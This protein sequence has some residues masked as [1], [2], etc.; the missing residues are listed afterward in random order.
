MLKLQAPII[1]TFIQP[2]NKDFNFEKFYN[3]LSDKNF[4]IY[5]SLKNYCHDTSSPRSASYGGVGRGIINTI[6]NL[7]QHNLL[8]QLI[9]IT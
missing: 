7:V 4:L 2:N 5:T 9:N 3:A 8:N 6:I 1:V